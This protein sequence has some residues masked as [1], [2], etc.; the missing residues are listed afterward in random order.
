MADEADS[1]SVGG[2]AVWVQVPLP[3]YNVTIKFRIR[4]FVYSKYFNADF[5][6]YIVNNLKND[7]I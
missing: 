5:S 2:N 1:K 7:V 3:A 4:I 6:Y